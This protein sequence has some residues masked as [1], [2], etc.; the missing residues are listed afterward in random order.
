[1]KGGKN[2]TMRF[3]DVATL[4]DEHTPGVFNTIN[5]RTPVLGEY[6][7]SFLQWKPISYTKTVRDI[8]D[9]IDVTSYG[10]QPN[11]ANFNDCVLTSSLLCAYYGTLLDELV[12]QS[13]NISFGTF[14]DG[15]YNATPHIS[16]T[17]M[18]G[19]GEPPEDY[20]SALVVLVVSIG[21]GIPALIILVSSI[22]IIYKRLSKPRDA[23][24]LGHM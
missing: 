21:F 15:F 13:A 6:D 9:S 16:W 23:V 5:L 14:K 3:Y 17:F 24:L 20:V 11:S 7:Q 2:D 8:T 19:Y 18:A 12:V 4:D 22:Y 10:L 1:V